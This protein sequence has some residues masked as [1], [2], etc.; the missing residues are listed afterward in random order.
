M[1]LVKMSLAAAMLMGASAFA[2]DNVK[3]SGDAKVFYTTWDNSYKGT[4][5]ATELDNGL[6]EKDSSAADAALHLGMT[7]DLTKGVSAGVGMTAI[8]TLGLENNLVSNTW[9]GAHGVSAATGASYYGHAGTAFEGIQADDAMWVDEAWI[10]G[11]LGKTT[12]KLGRMELDTPLAFTENWGVDKNTFEA[13]V[14]LNQDLPDTTL[15]AAWVGKGNGAS[16]EEGAGLGSGNA[17]V[18]AAGYVGR[19]GEFNTYAHD[20]AY[21]AGLVTT[22]IPSVTAQAWYY[23][24][25]DVADAYWLQ[26]DVNVE[27]ILL[28]AQYTDLS[29]KGDAKSGV[30]TPAGKKDDSAY[31]V[32]AGYEMKDTAT[33]KVAYSSVDEDGARGV[34]NTATGLLGGGQSKLYTEGWWIFNAG[35]PGTD[36]ISVSVEATV[37]DIDLF[38]A[39]YDF[40]EDT[41]SSGVA[42]TD[43]VDSQEFVV[44]ASKDMGPLN[45]TVAVVYDAYDYEDEA[46]ALAANEIDDTTMLH[47]YLT[48]SF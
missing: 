16:D 31:A 21:A 1:K 45:A 27:G 40:S 5:A 12:A 28:G 7:A 17:G 22:A 44:S 43:N 3:V 33:V 42:D 48:Y 32:M 47:V 10:A 26:A 39:Y 18:A 14:L 38:A 9:S 19:N 35:T 15:V 46:A 6:F 2:I 41:K 4:P 23:N 29:Y 30:V 24:V 25:V 37:A 11:T 34:G 36:T 20:G 13:A 8:S